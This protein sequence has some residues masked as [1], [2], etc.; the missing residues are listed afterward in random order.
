MGKQAFLNLQNK[1]K[2]AIFTAG[3]SIADSIQLLRAH[4]LGM[5]YRLSY[6]LQ[7]LQRIGM[8]MQREKAANQIE[9]N[10]IERLIQFS[11]NHVLRDIKH[12]AR[13]PI[14]ESY[15]LVGV[16]DEGPAYVNE[17]CENVF[18]LEEGQ[19]YGTLQ[20]NSSSPEQDSLDDLLLVCIQNHDDPEPTYLQGKPPCTSEIC[21]LSKL[22]F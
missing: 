14:P 2:E 20:S 19:V 15:L 9:D 3:D 6:V 10:F 12:S 7:N 1:A 21:N 8:G 4:R 13:I 11:K 17:G 18:M 16:A 5:S 22:L